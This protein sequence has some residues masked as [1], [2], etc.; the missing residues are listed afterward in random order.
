MVVIDEQHRFGV[1]QRL[2]LASKGKRTACPGDDRDTDPA[3]AD[4]GAIWRTRRQQAR[5]TA[6]RIAAIDTVVM[7]QEKLAALVDWLAAQ[8][9]EGRQAYCA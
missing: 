4:A 6:T 3:Y 9:V 8:M 7:G 5:R 1:G 2:M